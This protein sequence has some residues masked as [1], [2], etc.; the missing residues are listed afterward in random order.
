MPR[1]VVL[2]DLP[3]FAEPVYTASKL[4]PFS[5]SL[6]ISSWRRSE[7]EKGKKQGTRGRW[8][9]DV[10]TEDTVVAK[11]VGQVMGLTMEPMKFED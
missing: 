4:L 3:R 9:D 10:K 6:P 1:L 11:K 2:T 8:E 7:E 5:L